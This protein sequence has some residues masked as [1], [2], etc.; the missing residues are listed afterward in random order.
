MKLD[1]FLISQLN[2]ANLNI[3]QWA[4]LNNLDIDY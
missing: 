1:P 2:E 3:E 4:V